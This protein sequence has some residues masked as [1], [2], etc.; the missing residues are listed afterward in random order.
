[1]KRLVVLICVLIFVNV[2]SIAQ[3]PLSFSDSGEV[4]TGLYH[5]HAAWGDYDGDEVLDFAICG[6][7]ASDNIY[8]KLYDSF[9]GHFTEVTTSV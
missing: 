6:K 1:M 9:K 7:D 3:T 4:F 5:S 8:F 2:L